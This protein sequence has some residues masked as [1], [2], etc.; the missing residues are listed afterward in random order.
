MVMTFERSGGF[1]DH[2]CWSRSTAKQG[3]GS[4]KEGMR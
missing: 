3:E 4:V 1:G 2:R